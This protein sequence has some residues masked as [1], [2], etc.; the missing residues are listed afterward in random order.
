MSENAL[1]L[2]VVGTG[3]GVTAVVVSVIAVVANGINGRLSALGGELSIR[4]DKNSDRIDRMNDRLDALRREVREDHAALD[5]RL[6]RGP[7]GVRQGRPAAR[8]RRARRSPA[9]PARRLIGHK[10]STAVG[11]NVTISARSK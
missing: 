7:G 3:I 2:S 9:G 10:N 8:D 6:R 4:I 11:K 1:L 5:A